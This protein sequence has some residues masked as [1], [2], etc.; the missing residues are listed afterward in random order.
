MKLSEIEDGDQIVTK[1]YLNV[2][3][4]RLENKIDARFNA[5]EGKFNQQWI[6]FAALILTGVV[7]IAIGIAS[8]WIQ[9]LK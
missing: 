3:L 4:G 9:H 2:A 5:L 6:W 1:D 8:A 7:Q